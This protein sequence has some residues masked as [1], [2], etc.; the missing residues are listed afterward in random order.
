MHVVEEVGAVDVDQ[1]DAATYERERSGVR[2]PSGLR[3]RDVDDDAN[4]RFEQSLRRYAV[5]IGVVDDRDV[6]G[7]KALDEVLR[8]AVELGVAGQLDEAHRPTFGR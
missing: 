1:A 3:L 2:K 8:P 7:G 5:E 6:V 4:A